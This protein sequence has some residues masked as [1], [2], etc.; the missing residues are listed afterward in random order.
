MIRQR[1]EWQA[2][3]EELAG[4]LLAYREDHRALLGKVVH[5]HQVAGV[6]FPKNGKS[7]TVDDIDPFSVFALLNRN[8]K[9]EKKIAL[10]RAVRDEFSVEA[11]APTDFSGI[12]HADNRKAFLFP[13]GPRA[14]E[15]VEGLWRM[16]ET[17]LA[18]AD[19]KCDGGKFCARYTQTE[20]QHGVNRNLTMGLF[21][22]RPEFFVNLDHCNTQFIFGSGEFASDFTDNYSP[23]ADGCSD[24]SAYLDFCEA[25]HREISS[26]VS[27]FESFPKLSLA[28]YEW[29]RRQ[30]IDK[31][32]IRFYKIG[33]HPNDVRQDYSFEWCRD[34]EVAIGWN[35]LGDIE[36]R[37]KRRDGSY[38]E[39]KIAA[40]LGEDSS[41]AATREAREIIRF[42]EADS[43][44][45]FVVMR[46]MSIVGLVDRIGPCRFSKEHADADRFAHCRS[47][48]WHRCF[49]KDQRLPEEYEG[50]RRTCVEITDKKNRAFLLKHY[51]DTVKGRLVRKGVRPLKIERNVDLGALKKRLEKMSATERKSESVQRLGQGELR[52]YLLAC[53]GCCAITKIRTPELLVA[54]HIK[55]WAESSVCEQVDVENVL[56]LAKNYDAAFDK[57]LI[58]FAADTGKIMKASR[59]SWGELGLLGIQ[60]NAELPKPTEAQAKYLRHHLAVMKTKDRKKLACDG[61]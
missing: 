4:K 15:Y 48:V 47:G 2:F 60:K 58:S 11:A 35:W 54:S 43:N 39:R 45:V 24:G 29:G 32:L 28:A 30:K 26:S 5:A 33:C 18:Y 1:F 9:D 16:F 59:I 57:H 41:G 7:W 38:D 6:N 12:P 37:F 20:K 36:K 13:G 3:Y 40:A 53:D 44:V 31:K 61:G 23:V 49:G 27:R 46:G 56:L 21:W 42:V 19:G 52:K 51:R 55:G 50:Y 25:L 14:G 17:A 8:L 22:I 10:Q 34:G